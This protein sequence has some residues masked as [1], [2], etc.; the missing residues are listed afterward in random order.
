MKNKLTLFFLLSMFVLSGCGALVSQEIKDINEQNM[1][2]A[3]EFKKQEEQLDQ[4]E[5]DQAIQEEEDAFRNRVSLPI[6]MNEVTEF[7]ESKPG[8]IEIDSPTTFESKM[9]VNDDYT[10]TI[11]YHST[12]ETGNVTHFFIGVDDVNF[13]TNENIYP[14]MFDLFVEL[15]TMVDVEVDSATIE[16]LTDIAIDEREITYEELANEVILEIRPNFNADTGEFFSI[17]L[18][19]YQKN[20]EN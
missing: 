11:N 3:E 7:I 13:K 17:Q 5:I 2:E 15:L 20:E 9:F 1:L 6:S 19:F 10:L 18:V 14:Y 8:L 12:N 4:D 16:Q